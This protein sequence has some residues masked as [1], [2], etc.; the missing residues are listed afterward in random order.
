MAFRINYTISSN[1]FCSFCHSRLT[2]TEIPCT[3]SLHGQA[4]LFSTGYSGLG[5][6]PCLCQ[7]PVTHDSVHNVSFSINGPSVQSCLEHPLS[8]T[9]PRAIPGYPLWRCE[10]SALIFTH[11]FFQAPVRLLLSYSE[12]KIQ[13]WGLFWPMNPD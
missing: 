9:Q 5:K 10:H 1:S 11:C 7:A 8:S 6:L 13:R 4:R 3:A 2:E 12:V